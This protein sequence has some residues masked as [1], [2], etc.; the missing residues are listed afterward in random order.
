LK[1]HIDSIAYD[2]VKKIAEIDLDF[3]KG[4]GVCAR[5]C[6]FKAIVMKKK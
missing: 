6:P 5:V 1:Y 4:C 3:C 2:K